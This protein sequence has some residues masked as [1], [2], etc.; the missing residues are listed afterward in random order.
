MQKLEV[1]YLGVGL[2]L[3]SVIVMVSL[4][5]AQASNSC[6]DCLGAKSLVDGDRAISASPFI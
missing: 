6:S 1:L 4:E 3:R 2:G 5:A